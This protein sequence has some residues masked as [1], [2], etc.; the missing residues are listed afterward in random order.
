MRAK[1]VACLLTVLLA[2]VLVVPG[3]WAK[4]ITVAGSV[5]I[6]KVG[7][8]LTTELVAAVVTANPGLEKTIV[9]QLPLPGPL[10]VLPFFVDAEKGNPQGGD[11]DTTL[12][13]TNTTAAPLSVVVTLRALDG[14][15]LAT[16]PETLAANETRVIVLSDLLP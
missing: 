9:Q 16:V 6:T 2:A 3:V 15:T 12:L 4:R 10:F 5:T 11:I 1:A 13:V 7:G 14:S 8:A